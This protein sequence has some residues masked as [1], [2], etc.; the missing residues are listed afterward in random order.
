M[1]PVIEYKSVTLSGH[2]KQKMR[3]RDVD[4]DELADVLL[5]PQIIEPSREMLRLVRDDLCAVVAID[6]DGNAT[7]VTVL[8]RQLGA[9]TDED[10]RSRE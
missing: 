4:A 8:L 2:A 6:A 5:R 1:A 7:V 9:W 10:I 3:D